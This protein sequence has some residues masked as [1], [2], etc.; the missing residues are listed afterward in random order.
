[1][2]KIV[3]VNYRELLIKYIQYIEEC[4]GI[5]FITDLPKSP[6]FVDT[7]FT[8]EEWKELIKLAD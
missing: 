8:V 3:S 1:M 7:V 2:S 6:P 5:N 4:E